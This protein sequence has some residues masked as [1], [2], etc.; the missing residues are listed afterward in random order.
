MTSFDIPAAAR[1]LSEVRVARPLVHNITNY[2]AMTL[3][4]NVLLAIGASPAMVHAVEEV[5]DFVA[6]SSS[7]V[8]NIG[9]LSPRWVEG[10]G[11]AARKANALG[12]PWVL[13]PVGCGATPYRTNVAVS[14][15]TLRPTIIRGNASE[16]MSLAGA[17]GAGGQG[18]D[19]TA[20]S[21]EA[22]QAARALAAK[23]GAVVAVTG[24]T[25]YVCDARETVAITGGDPL[26]PLSTALGCSLSAVTA[27]FAAVTAPRDA[28]VAA[29]AIYGAAGAEAALRCGGNG[30]G[31]LPAELCDA[32]YGAD[33][34]MLE[35]HATIRTLVPA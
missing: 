29:L 13:D 30:P 1:A 34:A 9:T 18:V 33:Q 32:L 22:L 3:S 5:E 6:I 2:V 27:A 16:I 21:G 15:A 31:H 20:S 23:T 4:A 12:K 24:E 28:A 19:S 26:M 25:D 11:L 35:R 10:M 14:L 7:L 17:A 8:V